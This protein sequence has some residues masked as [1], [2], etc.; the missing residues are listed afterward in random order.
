MTS[1]V[2]YDYWVKGY[3]FF[4]KWLFL[5]EDDRGKTSPRA[6][7][8]T[9]CDIQSQRGYHMRESESCLCWILQPVEKNVNAVSL[10]L[11]IFHNFIL[12]E[13]I[14]FQ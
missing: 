11:S 10:Y 14:Y 5:G 8:F 3:A 2:R 12:Y 1:K 7:V 9:R 6:L 13:S 4:R